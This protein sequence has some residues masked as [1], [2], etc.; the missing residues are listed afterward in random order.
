MTD[1]DKKAVHRYKQSV[2]KQEIFLEPLVTRLEELSNEPHPKLRDTLRIIRLARPV[3]RQLRHSA[4]AGS[5]SLKKGRRA[6]LRAWIP[7]L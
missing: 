4:D 2:K 7:F 3:Y 5:P 1:I 6:Y